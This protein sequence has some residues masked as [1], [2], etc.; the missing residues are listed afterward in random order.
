MN[1]KGKYRWASGK[2]TKNVKDG[3]D[4]ISTLADQDLL[5]KIME[6]LKPVWD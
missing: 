3:H 5:E 1:L 4:L 2:I 6:I